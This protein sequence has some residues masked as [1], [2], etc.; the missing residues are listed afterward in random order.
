MLALLQTQLPTIYLKGKIDPQYQ[1]NA[2]HPKPKRNKSISVQPFSLHFQGL[3]II[4]F[5][6]RISYTRI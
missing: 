1:I 3:L 6:D 4:F 5:S 2:L